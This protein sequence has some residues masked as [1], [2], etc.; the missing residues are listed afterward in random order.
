ME[1]RELYWI[2]A[3]LLGFTV[4][5][6][7]FIG[8]LALRR[9]PN[10]ILHR[11]YFLSTFFPGSWALLNL[12][13]LVSPHYQTLFLNRLSGAC[14]PLASAAFLFFAAL[15]PRHGKQR[16]KSWMYAVAAAAIIGA[17]L[18]FT[19]LVISGLSPNGWR[20]VGTAF[21]P[22]AI[23]FIFT[24]MGVFCAGVVMLFIKMRT[25]DDPFD[26]AR[27]MLLF[28]GG[29][30]PTVL[31]PPLFLLPYAL[32]NKGSLCLLPLIMPST[33]ALSVIIN[34]YAIMRYQLFDIRLIWRSAIVLVS[35]SL[36]QIIIIISLVALTFMSIN[37]GLL[38][39]N[40]VVMIIFAFLAAL[41]SPSIGVML[42]D[43]ADRFLFRAEKERERRVRDFARSSLQSKPLKEL[44]KDVCGFLRGEFGASAA[45]IFFSDERREPNLNIIFAEPESFKLDIS[46][47][48]KKSVAKFSKTPSQIITRYEIEVAGD[49]H[50]L[51]GFLPLFIGSGVEILIPLETMEN[52]SGG[53]FIGRHARGGAY[54]GQ[55]LKLIELLAASI[56][57][58]LLNACMDEH[59]Q[60]SHRKYRELFERAGDAILLVSGAS[61]LILETNTIAE[62][63]FA[64]RRENLIGKPLSSLAAAEHQKPLETLVAN[65]P[66]A[67]TAS[68]IPLLR[69]GAGTFPAEVCS[70]TLENGD[71]VV[72]VRDIT[73]RK[74]IEDELLT[75]KKIESLGVLAG[76]V[77]HDF[78]NIIAAIMGSAEI[79]LKTMPEDDRNRERMERI[80]KSSQRARDI[81]RKLLAFARKEK[82]NVKSASVNDLVREIID[83]I[84]SDKDVKI[85]AN[86]CGELPNVT[87]DATQI[88]Q[89]IF[90]ICLNSCDFLGDGGELCIDTF[91]TTL[92]DGYRAANGGLAP[93]NYCA[94]SIRDNGKGIPEDVLPKIFEPFFTTKENGKG[95]GLGLSVAIGIVRNHNGH[96]D[97]KSKPG[98]GA[99][100]IIYL[101]VGGPDVNGNGKNGHSAPARETNQHTILIVDD[102]PDFTS[103]VVEALE[104]DGYKTITAHNGASGV[105]MFRLH[106]DEIS[107][108]LLDMIMPGGLDGADTFHAI[109]SISP[110]AAIA[111]C[112]GYSVD[113]KASSLLDKGACAFIQKPFSFNE[114]SSVIERAL[115][116]SQK[117]KSI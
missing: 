47:Q 98:E 112:S 116:V 36:I 111:V 107:V 38:S 34:A 78:G 19:P 74:R 58:A 31:G 81:T 39:A 4:F 5:S 106:K 33:S 94:I 88:Y 72:N 65:D 60:K 85:R 86:L 11:S 14:L 37:N 29:L 23:P 63:I 117:A 41:L 67:S 50:P 1:H 15:A 109:R 3:L 49:Q 32:G 103:T 83:S 25:A 51:R 6:D 95:T 22:L 115:S 77:A 62:E 43:I 59:I 113:G 66:E 114:L 73:D 12:L 90:N 56:A 10:S 69:D 54:R 17:A 76:G 89:T 18:S 48:L 42:T 100:A 53:I 57:P 64:R 79:T 101:P 80:V 16:P 55:A 93:G 21:G 24:W 28:I 99:C 30:I 68:E 70:V 13:W 52:C 108:V 35:Q 9:F 82:L 27:L 104:T 92:D 97:I 84:A 40:F 61:R 7:F 87:M 20:G 75:M 8:A 45:M 44:A 91:E 96:I 105:E 2:A 102:E 71:I 110:N 46:E 26:K